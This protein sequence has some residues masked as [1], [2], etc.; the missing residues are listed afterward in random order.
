MNTPLDRPATADGLFLWVMHR[1]AE[2]FADHAI[3][4]GGMAMRLFDSPRSTTDIDYVFV[5]YA[6]KTDVRAQIESVL[7]E[8]DDAEVKVALHSKMLRAELRVDGASIQVEVNVAMNCNGIA[9]STAGFARQL[10]QPPRVVRIMSPDWALAHKLA[11]WSER[12]LVRDLYDCYFFAARLQQEPAGEVLDDRLAHVESRIP[13]Q[14]RR[15]TMTRAE[16]AGELREVTS[17]LSQERVAAELGGVLPA[18]ELA[19]LALRIR[20]AV[21]KIAEWLEEP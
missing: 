18:E 15:K 1:F 21:V 20:A 12:R 8:I 17:S 19:G 13:T 11:A 14:S 4:K 2:V 9:M 5:P 10:G 3:L 6:S 7:R 16:L